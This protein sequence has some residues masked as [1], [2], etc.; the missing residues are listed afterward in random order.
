MQTILQDLNTLK[1]WN[2]NLSR[3]FV[4]IHSDLSF[5]TALVFFFVRAYPQYLHGQPNTWSWHWCGWGEDVDLTRCHPFLRR[6]L[7]ERP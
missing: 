6:S 7:A 5:P 2:E 1:L 3:S 4:A